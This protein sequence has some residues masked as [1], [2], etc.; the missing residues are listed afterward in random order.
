[1]CKYHHWNCSLS[2]PSYGRG[3]GGGRLQQQLI[4][5]KCTAIPKVVFDIIATAI[6][7]PPRLRL[8]PPPALR[9]CC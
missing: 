4:L 6:Q 9:P 7:S 1:M 2:R 3:G 5:H 8:P